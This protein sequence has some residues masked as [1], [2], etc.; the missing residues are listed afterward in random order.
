MV[1]SAPLPG[2]ML[3]MAPLN[4]EGVAFRPRKHR[5]VPVPAEDGVQQK[6]PDREPSPTP[7]FPLWTAWAPRPESNLATSTDLSKICV[8]MLISSDVFGIMPLLLSGFLWV[9]RLG[10]MDLS[11]P[12]SR[13]S[14]LMLTLHWFRRF[15]SLAENYTYIEHLISVSH[16]KRCRLNLA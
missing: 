16:R 3:E 14:D 6:Q 2:R 9:H 7:S 10:H 11:Q 4:T 15:F 5:G 8:N 1:L 12:A 13:G